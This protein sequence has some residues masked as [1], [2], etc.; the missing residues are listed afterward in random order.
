MKRILLFITAIFSYQQS[1]TQD[2]NDVRVYIEDLKSKAIRDTS[3]MSDQGLNIFMAKKVNTYLTGSGDLS[4]NKNY[5]IIDPTDGRLFLG[6]NWAKDPSQDTFRTKWIF[7][8]GIKSN[9]AEAFSTIYSGKDKKLSNNT[10]LALKLTLLGRGIIYFGENGTQIQTKELKKFGL[11]DT[12]MDRYQQQEIANYYREQLKNEINDLIIIDSTK[13]ENKIENTGT[14][15][16]RALKRKEFYSKK[17]KFYKKMFIEEESRYI[18]EEEIYNAFW[19]HWVSLDIYIPITRQQ[20]RVAESFT[21]LIEDRMLYNFEGTLIWSNIYERKKM[22]LLASIGL[23]T[24][25]MN[26]ITTAELEKYSIGSYKQLGGTDTL[27]LA[28]IKTDEIYIGNYNQFFIPLLKFNLVNFFLANKQIGLSLLA[29]K[30]FG[31]YNPLNIKAG[32]PFNLKGKD[33]DTKVSF[34]LQFKWNDINNNILPDVNPSDKF[35]I[36]L[37][38]GIPLTSQL[39]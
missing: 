29:E 13:F 14:E 2:F 11:T 33:D 10:G 9:V 8:T 23:G 7:T 27:S 19:N 21:A 18:E 3:L 15:A 35:M 39:Y 31:A 37:S 30:H 28:Q 5:F 32:I 25:I 34:E 4:M 38:V 16:F 1:Y 20:Y 26:N 17:A 24:K 12:T 6:H 36:G 22:R